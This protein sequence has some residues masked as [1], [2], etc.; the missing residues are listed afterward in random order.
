MHG[1]CIPN[2]EPQCWF[3]RMPVG[4]HS[5]SG[6]FRRGHGCHSPTDRPFQLSDNSEIVLCKNPT[7]ALIRVNTTLF[8][9]LC[10]YMFQ[11]PR[12]HL[13]GIMIHFVSRVNT[14][15]ALNI[16]LQSTA[17][18][19]TWQLSNW[20]GISIWTRIFFTL[21]TKC[22]NTPWGRSLGGSNM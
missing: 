15:P 2:K 5:W 1:H 6:H 14:C 9:L 20:S 21:L 16:I 7:N 10:C 13:W 11:P 22:I 8:T 19:G 17:L 3:N 12:G 4:H 18:Y